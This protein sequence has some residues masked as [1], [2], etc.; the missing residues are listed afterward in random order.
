MPVPRHSVAVPSV[1]LPVVAGCGGVT[2][3]RVHG[4]GGTPPDAIL[5]DLAPEQ[6]MGD[7]IAGFYRSSDHRASDPD[8]EA[9]ADADRHVEVYSWGGL[10]SGSKVRVLWLALLPFLLGNLAGWMCSARTRQSA[11]R[12]RLHRLAA[13]LG[14]LALTVNTALIA[15]MIS[16]DVIAYQTTRAGLAR[17]QW[18]LAP[19]GWPYISGYPARQVMLGVLVPVLFVLALT[20]LAGTTWRYEA[21][22]PPRLGDPPAESRLVTAAALPR[23]LADNE[24]WDG[25]NSVRVV[26]WVH[27]AVAGGFLAIALG[28]TVQALS[29]A[30]SPHLVALGW[31]GVGLGAATVALGAG[32]ICLDALGTPPT[33]AP[34]AVGPAVGA[35]AGRLRGWVVYLLIPAAVALVTSGLFAWLQPAGP[36]RRAAD[37]PGM[38]AVTG[39]TALAIAVV[40][41]LALISALLGLAGTA[42][43][44]KGASW[45]TLMLGFG[46]LNLVLLG[47]QI[48][49]AHLVG[50]VTGNPARA[51]ASSPGQIYLPQVITAGVPLLAWAAVL[52]ILASGLAEASRWL[53]ARQ[54]PQAAARQYRDAAAAFRGPLTGPQKYWYWSGLAP[55]PPPADESGAA[56]PAA[57]RGWEQKIARTRFLARAPHDATWLLWAIIGGQLIMAACVWQLRIQPP[58]IIGTLGVAIIGLA[59]PA[60]MAWLY[61]AWS[62][63]AKRRAIG[64]V[65]DVG[66]FWPRSYH[67]LSPPCYTER[68]IPELQRRM[69]WLHDNGGR[70]MLTAHSQGTVLAAAALV[71]PGCRPAGDQPALI[72]FGSPLCKLYAWGFPGYFDPALL[73][74]L[75]PG[76][77]GRLNAWRNFYY[78]TDPIGGPVAA[79]LS[80]DTGDQVDQELLDPADCYYVY[81]Q[82]PPAAQGHCG[83]WADPRVWDE[84]NR[85]AAGLPAAPR[86]ASDAGF[87]V[88]A[89]AAGRSSRRRRQR[90]LRYV[91]AAIA[92]C[93]AGV[94]AVGAAVLAD[95]AP[96]VGAAV[97]L[98]V[99]AVTML[100]SQGL[101]TVKER[102]SREKAPAGQAGVWHIAG[103]VAVRTI[104]QG[105][106]ARDAWTTVGDKDHVDEPR[107]ESVQRYVVV[108]GPEAVAEE[109]TF[110]I[111]AALL[112]ELPPDIPRASPVDVQLTVDD[113]GRPTGAPAVTARIYVSPAF[114]VLSA[115]EAEFDVIPDSDPGPAAF[116]LRCRPGVQGPQELNVILSQG[117][118]VLGAVKLVIKV[119]AQATPANLIRQSLTVPAIPPD[120]ASPPDVV[121]KVNRVT[122]QGR[123]TLHYTYEWQ[124]RDWPSVDAGSVE[125]SGTADEWLREK[126]EELGKA[127]RR[128]VPAS[129]PLSADAQSWPEYES[130]PHEVI[131][132]NL[133]YQLF[134]DELRAFYAEFAA[135]ARTLLIFSDEPWIPW[136]L[137]KPWGAGLDDADSEFLCVKFEMSRWYYSS[138]CQIPKGQLDVREIAPV[139]PPSDLAAVGDEARYIRGLPGK[140]PAVS[141]C[142][143]L[144]VRRR[145]VMGVLAGGRAQV[146]HFAT[147]GVLLGGG[148]IA[149]I[150]LKDGLLKAEEIVGNRV[151]GGLKAATPSSS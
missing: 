76:G 111:S 97:G 141:L 86:P 20:W 124:Q 42:G 1:Q 19:L 92:A 121:I 22:R 142:R 123:D 144:P 54:L 125:L 59:L 100:A 134:T 150:M 4:V 33:D 106:D 27:V 36:A 131:G 108:E 66:T 26:T 109:S 12:F 25:G 133:Y 75:E 110:S 34:G 140:W 53:R 63:P 82:A 9:R 2:E 68:A 151:A 94:A 118:R 46:T 28:V 44:L 43:T 58:V 23:G 107:A 61:A 56:P 24:F 21:V 17:H 126:L 67:P 120:S 73:E 98:G 117:W 87:E 65:W 30:G 80:P 32:Y 41:A 31:L 130:L 102:R 35:L 64:V 70:V 45:V 129:P 145:D 14:T 6:V 10:T 55:Y 13:G 136:E 3:L 149:S 60:L 47:A 71:Q 138:Q 5:G 101:V 38:A 128:P 122:F 85:I 135:E 18:W 29:A 127:A 105:A 37:L 112:R 81:G 72:T 84:I 91:L 115:K 132:K 89:A 119:G 103:D 96:V 62:D 90:L 49:V 40:A 116:R 79:A 11:W 74:P 7:A 104:E 78:P 52:V 69:W 148:G 139:L 147:H 143:P 95:A 99:L 83:Y 15:V 77:T 16:A 114:E 8:R 50:P 51:L 39:W 113:S 48:W 57:G 146:L 88:E 137:V 93:V